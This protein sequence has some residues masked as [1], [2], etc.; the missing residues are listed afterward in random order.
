MD[1]PIVNAQ[2]QEVLDNICSN[3]S[4]GAYRTVILNRDALNYRQHSMPIEEIELGDFT[5]PWM[6]PGMHA[7]FDLIV[8]VDGNQVKVFKNRAGNSGIYP[9]RDLAHILF[10]SN[11]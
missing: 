3:P 4:T 9:L 11:G 10:R 5:S 1:K 2:V 7:A 6:N 8:F